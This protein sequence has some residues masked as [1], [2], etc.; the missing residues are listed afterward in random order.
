MAPCLVLDASVALKYFLT[1]EPD[2]QRALELLN[3]FLA[4]DVRLV[5]PSTIRFEVGHVLS[6]ATRGLRPRLSAD[7]AM[8]CFDDFLELPIQHK[9]ETPADHRQAF[10]M[11]MQFGRS[12]YDMTYLRLARPDCRWVT[13]DARVLKSPPSG[14]PVDRIVLLTEL[15]VA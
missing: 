12:Y 15:D 5:A 6:K 14:Y 11:A 1:D 2:S 8:A 13:A 3:A 9:L 10:Q 7:Q 4:G